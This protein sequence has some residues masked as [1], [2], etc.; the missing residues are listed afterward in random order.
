MNLLNTTGL[1]GSE[2]TGSTYTAV[3]DQVNIVATDINGDGNADLIITDNA[4]DHHDGHLVALVN[5]GNF[6]F[7]N[8]SSTY[9]PG[10]ANNANY[11]YHSRYFSVNNVNT[12]FVPTADANFNFTTLAD[13]FQKVTSYFQVF[14]QTRLST[15]I[16]GISSTSVAPTVYRASNGNLYVL[17]AVPI[18][19]GGVTSYA[20]YTNPL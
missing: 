4:T 12:L 17:T 15:A 14:D 13:M 3:H 6:S 16:S 20:F 9:F 11:Q 10:Q 5:S 1:P 8:Q 2:Y 18:I 19:T 7:S